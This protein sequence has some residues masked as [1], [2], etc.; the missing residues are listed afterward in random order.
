MIATVPSRTFS[1]AALRELDRRAVEDYGI[2]ILLLMENAGRA[3]ADAAARLL[4]TMD[5]SAGVLVLV[6]PG[7]N[8]ADALVAARHLAARGASVDILTIFNPDDPAILRNAQLATH[9][10]ITRALGLLQPFQ[11]SAVVGTLEM[12]LTPPPP[13]GRAP[14]VIIDGL[15]GTGLTRPL[16]G[17][18]RQIVDLLNAHAISAGH[19]VLA[20]DIPSGLDADTGLPVSA[21]NAPGIAAGA[22]ET[23]SFCGLKLGFENPAA[24]AWTG[25]VTVAPI[26]APR[27]LLEELGRAS[28]LE[29]LP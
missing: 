18:P 12:W 9:L 24:A 3:V 14:G 6:G 23:V 27:Q 8:G 26:G 29:P 15:F 4:T 11:E 25:R 13:T 22:T 19:Q 20:I 2:P 28:G 7:N 17:L 21:P 16:A 1:R 10:G 5:A